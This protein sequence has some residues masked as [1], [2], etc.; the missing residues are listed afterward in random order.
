MTTQQARSLRP[1]ATW[2][3][4]SLALVGASAAVRFAFSYEA[5]VIGK[6][7]VSGRLLTVEQAAAFN[8][9]ADYAL[10]T[11]AATVVLALRAMRRIQAMHQATSMEH[12]ANEK[13]REEIG[14]VLSGYELLMRRLRNAP[15]VRGK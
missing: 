13:L 7:A 1:F 9:R 14:E 6:E 3:T 2:T 12:R 15:E 11:W 8:A 10:W 4:L 5:A